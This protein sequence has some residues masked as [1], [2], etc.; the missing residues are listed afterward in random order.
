MEFAFSDEQN[1][2]RESAEGFLA[3]VSD[4]PAVRAAMG[5]ATG[6]D[7][8]LWQRLCGEMGWP[9]SRWAG[10]SRAWT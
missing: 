6:Y 10:P 5:S 7:P 1:M 3:D 4:S 2:I 9:P 8:A